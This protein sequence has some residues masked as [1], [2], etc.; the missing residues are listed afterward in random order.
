MSRFPYL[1]AG[2]LTAALPV[3][4]SSDDPI[5][6]FRVPSLPRPSPKLKDLRH[7]SPGLTASRTPPK[8]RTAQRLAAIA[9]ILPV[10]SNARTRASSRNQSYFTTSS[11][12]QQHFFRVILR[13]SFSKVNESEQAKG[14]QQFQPSSDQRESF[15]SKKSAVNFAG[16]TQYSRRQPFSACEPCHALLCRMA[17]RERHATQ[18]PRKGR[19]GLCRARSRSGRTGRDP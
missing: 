17:P 6:R 8:T 16:L 13:L 4:R 3:T 2:V 14:R 10:R 11:P 7:S 18:P 12:S 1:I 15:C 19:C 9:P 5:T